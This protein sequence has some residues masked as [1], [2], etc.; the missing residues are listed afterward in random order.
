MD[1]RKS[2]E[3]DVKSIHRIQLRA[4]LV[5]LALVSLTVGLSNWFLVHLIETQMASDLDQATSRIGD[6][7]AYRFNTILDDP[8][9]SPEDV[10]AWLEMAVQSDPQLG[11][12]AIMDRDGEPITH[13]NPDETHPWLTFL[14]DH[15]AEI[16]HDVSYTRPTI[17]RFDDG[18]HARLLRKPV[19]ST[20][21]T[22]DDLSQ[23][24][25][26]GSVILGVVDPFRQHTMERMR[27]LMIGVGCIA[28]LISVP[29]TVVIVSRFTR[30]LR[31][32][33][34]AITLLATQDT[35][36]PL[37]VDRKDEIGVLA[38]AFTATAQ[39]LSSARAR[40][41]QAN[42]TLE[43]QVAQRTEDL[44]R[45]HRKLEIEIATKNEF[46][47]TVSHDLNAPLRNI[48]GMTAMI[49]RRFGEALPDEVKTR[50][51]RISANVDLE[52][53]MLDDLLEISRI[54]TR[55]GK[56]T[57]VDLEALV[58]KIFDALSHELS[59][60]NISARIEG[61]LP[62][63]RVEE[64][65]ARQ[66]FQNL[67]DNAIK[68][69]GDQP[70]RQITVSARTVDQM[71]ELS[72]ADTGPGIDQEDQDRVF[73]VFRRGSKT[74]A[75]AIPGRGVGLASVRAVCEAW[76]GSIRLECTPGSGST[77]I[78]SIPAQR[79]A[80]AVCNA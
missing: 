68:Y 10:H 54:H 2:I 77:F 65:R 32:V 3:T 6:A 14:S 71:L 51:E 36:P 1:T 53:S 8:D 30:P 64:N 11:F 20:A 72:V 60:K 21:S 33:V 69:M 18:S 47:R 80:S 61:E 50:L 44:Q 9:T 67:I 19:L 29:L 17:I 59:E 79:V 26:L 76:G 43:N 25:F 48:A 34:R 37:P 66:V 74:S 31:K 40:L 46:L 78:V 24:Q 22:Q 16:I 4:V 28:C 38:R 27:A 39:Q 52:S 12:V 42:S 7:L 70:T 13:V 41:I 5:V 45:T 63:I 49:Q 62:T 56:V 35:L 73:T 58:Q 75:D 15:S 55:P 57:D 23:T